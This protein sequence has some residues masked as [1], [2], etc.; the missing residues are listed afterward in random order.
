MHRKLMPLSIRVACLACC[1]NALLVSSCSK[2]PTPESVAQNVA[3]AIR[4]KDSIALAG[5]I[6]DNEIQSLKA[7]RKSIAKLFEKEL[8]G[9]WTVKDV[10]VEY[11]DLQQVASGTA[12]LRNEFGQE[13]PY[14]FSAVPSDAGMETEGLVENLIWINALA[15]AHR[16]GKNSDPVSRR[17]IVADYIER[18]A[19]ELESVY[20]LRGLYYTEETG[21]VAWTDVV[22]RYREWADKNEQRMRPSQ[23]QK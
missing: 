3:S 22:K 6:S 18:R 1:A 2:P 9:A 7:D 5:L 21:M 15:E 8:F 12:M 13:L 10:T 11:L 16:Q 20:G 4:A 17:R 23:G 19:K 14:A